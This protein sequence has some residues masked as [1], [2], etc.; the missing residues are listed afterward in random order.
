MAHDLWMIYRFIRCR[1]AAARIW[2]CNRCGPPKKVTRPDFWIWSRHLQKWVFGNAESDRFSKNFWICVS[3]KICSLQIRPKGRIWQLQCVTL[4][5]ATDVRLH[6]NFCSWQLQVQ[7][8]P[9]ADLNLNPRATD[10][11]RQPNGALPSTY[12][13]SLD[14]FKIKSMVVVLV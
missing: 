3:P 5:D 13:R 10:H 6:S 4:P 14:G 9:W 8:R 2:I 12:T 1:S 11:S 7:I